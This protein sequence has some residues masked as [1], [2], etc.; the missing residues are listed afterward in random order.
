MKCNGENSTVGLTGLALERAPAQYGTL[1]SLA[2][3]SQHHSNAAEPSSQSR[4]EN[5]ISWY[6]LV[7]LR[8]NS[9]VPCQLTDLSM[10]LI[11]R[12]ALIHYTNKKLQETS[13][14]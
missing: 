10:T 14:A 6:C 3:S 9:F 8:P 12:H 11:P 5:Q 7:S 1:L 2:S 13:S 4:L